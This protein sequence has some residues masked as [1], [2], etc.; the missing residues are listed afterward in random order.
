[1]LHT[2]VNNTDILLRVYSSNTGT[3]LSNKG[4][5][6]PHNTANIDISESFIGVRSIS[7]VD[8][9]TTRDNIHCIVSGSDNVQLNKTFE[10]IGAN[11]YVVFF[12]FA[13]RQTLSFQVSGV[14]TF[15]ISTEQT[16]PTPTY[17]QLTQTLNNCISNQ[18]DGDI[19]D[20]DFSATITAVNGYQFLDNSVTCSDN[21]FTIAISN[22]RL[23]ATI[24]GTVTNDISITASATA[25]PVYITYNLAF[26][27]RHISKSNNLT[28][29]NVGDTYTNILTPLP[30]YYI[31]EAPILYYKDSDGFKT[32][33]A[34]SVIN[35]DGTATLTCVIPN[36]NN[37]NPLYN[38][39]LFIEGLASEH[40]S[41]NIDFGFVNM[42]NPTLSE[43]H[44][45]AEFQYNSSFETIQLTDFVLGVFKIFCDIPLTPYKENVYFGYIDSDVLANR[46]ADNPVVDCGKIVINEIQ[47]NSIDYIDTKTE[48]FLPFIGVRSIDVMKIMGK[49]LHLV[50]HVDILTGG[51]VALLYADN[52]LIESYN[53]DMSVNVP[54][55]TNN[56]TFMYNEKIKGNTDIFL[57]FTPYVLIR[58]NKPLLISNDID[59]IETNELK[60]LSTLSG[61][62]K[63]D[64][65]DLSGI[66]NANI[67][68]LTEIKNILYDGV[69]L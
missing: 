29:V 54:L 25:I 3:N 64:Y 7:S 61:Y 31:D 56:Y 46:V 47:E 53:G 55:S 27:L 13:N 43:L 37:F 49:T 67:N 15:T 35:I 26:D 33:L 42:Y 32:T 50:Y 40:I 45:L 39:T 41:Y 14:D 24:T 9:S 20:N 36:I 30:D 6:Q 65:I 21:S 8:D 57:G 44:D 58:Q 51:V 17:Y 4:D 16:P 48:I 59:G 2:F 23:S 22:D 63:F 62:N 34:T 52:V 66:H 11:P 10:S 19:L 18:I 69:I 68:E 60:Q 28:S 5:I 1:M 12:G 38:N